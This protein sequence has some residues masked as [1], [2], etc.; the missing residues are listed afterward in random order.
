MASLTG[1]GVQR[2]G[3]IYLEYFQNQATPNFADFSPSQSSARAGDKKVSDESP[4]AAATCPFRMFHTPFL[5]GG[6]LDVALLRGLFVARV[7]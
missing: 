5:L 1:R 7:D 3:T 4:T 6:D 2:P